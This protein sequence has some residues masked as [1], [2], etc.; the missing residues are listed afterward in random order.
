MAFV[1]RVAPSP[2]APKF[3]TLQSCPGACAHAATHQAS[4]ATRRVYRIRMVSLKLHLQ[5]GLHGARVTRTRD[6]AKCRGSRH[7][8][9]RRVEI[10][11]VRRVDGLDA[12]FRLQPLVDAEVLK[13]GS[14]QRGL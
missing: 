8:R 10:R 5:T 9:A 7:V 12:Q 3:R 13:R 11:M 2:F 1:S 4:S 14:V 6:H